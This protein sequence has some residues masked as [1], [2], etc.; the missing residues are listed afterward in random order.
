MPAGRFNARRRA[1]RVLEQQAISN[2]NAEIVRWIAELAHMV[3]I[4]IDR[5]I[6]AGYLIHGLQLI[7]TCRARR[8]KRKEPWIG[9]LSIQDGKLE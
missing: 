6:R 9:A 8:T 4:R 2:I 7:R 1:T 3:C 5:P